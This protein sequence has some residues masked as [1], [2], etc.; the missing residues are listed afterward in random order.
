M[1]K[2]MVCGVDCIPGGQ[3]CNN[4]C[5][6]D[7]SR[8]MADH[9]PDATSEQQRASAKRIAQA[10]LREAEAAWYEYY[11]LCEVGPERIWAAEVHARIHRAPAA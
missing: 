6:H 5:N 7:P 10:K 3:N 2:I 11:G 9:A 4:Y 8:P 1:Q